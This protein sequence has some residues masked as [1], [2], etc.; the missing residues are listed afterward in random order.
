MKYSELLIHFSWLIARD[1]RMPHPR[2][3]FLVP[4]FSCCPFHPFPE[5]ALPVSD[6][7][8]VLGRRKKVSKYERQDICYKDRRI[9]NKYETNIKGKTYVSKIRKSL[10]Q[11]RSE[12]PLLQSFGHTGPAQR[13][14]SENIS[15]TT[16]HN[17]Y[18]I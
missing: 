12:S 17:L 15:A 9:Q 6:S 10:K 13:L 4:F 14:K 8:S 1:C 3:R 2:Q 5:L 7:R 16:F 11:T 18:I